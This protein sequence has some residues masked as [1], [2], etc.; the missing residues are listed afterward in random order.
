MKL[1]YL[2]KLS[3][4]EL[5]KIA[6]ELD[7][8]FYENGLFKGSSTYVVEERVEFASWNQDY[9]SKEDYEY[10]TMEIN[11][12]EILDLDHNFEYQREKQLKFETIMKQKFKNTNYEKDAKDY[13]VKKRIDQI[14][15]NKQ[16]IKELENQNKE[17]EDETEIEN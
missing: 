3:E 13:F 10:N 17:L 8:Y 5:N 7:F 12:F 16:Q 14:E 1:K 11:D 15:K 9:S 2:N 4:K 6:N